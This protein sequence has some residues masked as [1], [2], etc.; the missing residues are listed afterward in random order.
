[1]CDGSVLAHGSGD[2]GRKSVTV[3]TLGLAGNEKPREPRKLGTVGGLLT[4]PLLPLI[5]AAGL[6]SIPISRAIQKSDRK[7]EARFRETM[8]AMNR[9][10]SPAE[11]TEHA[12]AGRGTFIREWKRL[13][14]GPVRLW[15][16]PEDAYKECGFGPVDL[17]KFFRDAQYKP[18]HNRC[19][20]HYTNRESGR[21]MLVFP[22]ERE[23]A[24]QLLENG[25]GEVRCI[26]IPMSRE[27]DLH[28]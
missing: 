1:M 4:L 22:P 12:R 19:W 25:F 13:F 10:I 2:E 20:S 6:I 28:R 16:T 23:L 9:T 27:R 15:W 5:F 7:K 24:V 8:Q 11:V 3:Q 21:A 17:M 26:D 14:K 18:I